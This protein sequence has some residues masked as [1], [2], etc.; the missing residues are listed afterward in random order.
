MDI[1]VKTSDIFSNVLVV[2]NDICLS[3]SETNES[4]DRAI[5]EIAAH[6][7]ADHI[8]NMIMDGDITRIEGLELAA[9]AAEN[10]TALLVKTN[11][12]QFIANLIRTVKDGK[13]ERM[14]S[15]PKDIQDFIK[16]RI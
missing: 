8:S 3:V 7:T 4:S 15:Y 16:S 9:E 12:K 14:S 13:M 1:K 6:I 2:S 5:T 11:V 10:T